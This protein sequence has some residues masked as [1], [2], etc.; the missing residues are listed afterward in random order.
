MG[1]MWSA[2]GRG[3]STTFCLSFTHLCQHITWGHMILKPS[4]LP[5]GGQNMGQMAFSVTVLGCRSVYLGGDG[6]D[7]FQVV[8]SSVKRPPLMYLTYRWLYDWLLYLLY[9]LSNA[10]GLSLYSSTEHLLTN[11]ES[12]GRNSSQRNQSSSLFLPSYISDSSQVEWK[13]EVVICRRER[14]GCLDPSNFNIWAESKQSEGR[15]I[16]PGL[17]ERGYRRAWSWAC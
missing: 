7:R 6:Y 2:E 3:K 8:G 13:H 15:G 12:S 9:N 4:H 10:F 16:K 17:G 5:Q 11:L 14:I 1:Q